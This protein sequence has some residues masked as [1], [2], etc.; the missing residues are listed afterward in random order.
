MAQLA[1][2]VLCQL[3]LANKVGV[4]G[5]LKVQSLLVRVW[6]LSRV[7]HLFG[8]LWDSVRLGRAVAGGLCREIC[9]LLLLAAW[10]D[11]CSF[12]VED[13]RVIAENGSIAEW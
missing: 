8:T 1:R 12:H 3:L 6:L 10:V 7:C 2:Q 11:L 4:G 5:R 9:K 13:R